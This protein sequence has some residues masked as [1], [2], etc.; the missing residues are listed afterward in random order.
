VFDRG[1]HYLKFWL[2]AVVNGLL[3]SAGVGVDVSAATVHLSID[4]Q[5][6][7]VMS[8][9]WQACALLNSC[10][11][12]VSAHATHL[13]DIVFPTWLRPPSIIK[14]NLN[15]RQVPLLLLVVGRGGFELRRGL[16]AVELP[17]DPLLIRRSIVAL[18]VHILVMLD[19]I[20]ESFVVSLVG[21]V[22]FVV[23]GTSF[24]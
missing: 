1:R 18:V 10:K 2:I 20:P 12:W 21:H 15:L 14:S 3:I 6:L 8:T 5:L 7:L 13:R 23:K 22:V 17:L 4:S 11:L 19:L 9:S 24:R 16:R